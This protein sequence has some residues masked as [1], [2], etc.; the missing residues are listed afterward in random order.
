MGCFAERPKREEEQLAQF[1]ELQLGLS[2][3]SSRSLLAILLTLPVNIS[4]ANLPELKQ[5][6]KLSD[7]HIT[8]ELTADFYE[9][10]E[11][12]GDRDFYDRWKFGLL[13]LILTTD[14]S[15]WKA[16]ALYQFCDGELTVSREKAAKRLEFAFFLASEAIPVTLSLNVTDRFPK[17]NL[18]G[19]VDSLVR[20]RP[21][22][23]EL[24]LESLFLDGRTV[25]LAAF[26][27]AFQGSL[28]EKCLISKGIREYIGN[29]GQGNERAVE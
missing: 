28:I 3:K 26:V 5:K 24:V 1:A 29:V 20:R 2:H 11:K 7:L 15:Q 25:G 23:L 16:E 10:F 8:P 27:K 9:C 18:L 6:L 22:A 13:V 4:K 17:A 12:E 21:E 14:A 19:Y